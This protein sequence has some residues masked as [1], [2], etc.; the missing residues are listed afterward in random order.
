MA[1]SRSLK[2]IGKLFGVK[3]HVSVASDKEF[4]HITK[5]LSGKFGKSFKEQRTIATGCTRDIVAPTKI[6]F[7]KKRGDYEKELEKR[8]EE[9]HKDFQK[10]LVK[11]LSTTPQNKIGTGVFGIPVYHGEETEK[12]HKMGNMLYHFGMILRSRKISKGKKLKVKHGK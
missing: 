1:K 6:K 11:S 3:T 8:M 12:M 9:I 4:K 10:E 2:Y 5:L 7:P